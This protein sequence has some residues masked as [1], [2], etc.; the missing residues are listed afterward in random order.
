MRRATFPTC[1]DPAGNRCAAASHGSASVFFRLNENRLFAQSRRVIATSTSCPTDR[2]SR[3]S[4]T[5]S[6]PISET[7]SSPS[8]GPMSTNAP[9]SR[10]EVTFPRTTIPSDRVAIDSSRF[11]C[12]SSSTSTRLETT[13]LRPFSPYCEIRNGTR[14]PT[15]SAASLPCDDPIC[16]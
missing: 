7:G 1:F 12:S 4:S 2:T 9:K 14:F 15:C 8:I 13:M 11:R 10:R 16:E 5:R 3:M 6:Q